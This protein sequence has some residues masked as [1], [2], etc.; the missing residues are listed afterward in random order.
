MTP[1]CAALK[2]KQPKGGTRRHQGTFYG[3]LAGVWGD[4]PLGPEKLEARQYAMFFDLGACNF[5]KGKGAVA[6]TPSYSHGFAAHASNCGGSTPGY[7]YSM[8]AACDSRALTEDDWHCVANVYDGTAI[9]AYVNDSI[10]YNPAGGNRTT[11][12]L[13]QSVNPY[14]HTFS[15]SIRDPPLPLCS[16][17][18]RSRGLGWVIRLLFRPP[19]PHCIHA[20]PCDPR[21]PPP[22]PA[23]FANEINAR[24]R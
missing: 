23:C 9:N 13:E 18:V 17:S 5:Y 3:F 7:P 11:P 16:C 6:G 4:V 10:I 20:V 12:P 19:L 2:V 24:M 1:C 22:P 15:W 21:R 8:T 14:A